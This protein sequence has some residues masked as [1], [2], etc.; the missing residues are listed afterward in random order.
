[1]LCAIHVTSKGAVD[2]NAIQRLAAFVAATGVND[3]VYLSDQESALRKL[4]DAAFNELAN[5]SNIV[6]A[7]PEMSAVGGEPEQRGGRNIC[8]NVGGQAQDIQ[9]RL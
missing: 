4:F 8:P 3:L 2:S 9:A 7:V 6:R 1:M 5:D